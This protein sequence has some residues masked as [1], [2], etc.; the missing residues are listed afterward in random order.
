MGILKIIFSII[1]VRGMAHE[2][3]LFAQTTAELLDR[4]K[5]LEMENRKLSR[6]KRVQEKLM[7]TLRLNMST[8]ENF[9]KMMQADKVRLDQ[10]ISLLLRH[11][12][13]AIFLLDANGR[14][15]VGTEALYTLWG[16]DSPG[17][18]TGREFSSITK[19]Y[20]P[21]GLGDALE[22]AVQDAQAAEDGRASRTAAAGGKTFEIN[23]LTYG[24]ANEAAGVLV[25]MHDASELYGAKE[26]AERASRAKSDFLANMSHEMRTPMNAIIGMTS[27]ARGAPDLEKKDYCLGKIADASTHLLGVI[28]DILDMSKI[29]ANKFEL[30]YSEFNFEKML[31]KVTNVVNFRVEEKKQVFN[32]KIDQAIPKTLISDE[33]RLSQVIANLLSNAVKFT[34]EL[35]AITLTSQLVSRQDDRLRLRVSVTDTGIGISEEQQQRL[36]TSFVQAD[37]GISRKFGGTGLGLA[38]SRNIVEMM[39]G[40]I[41]VESTPNNGSCFTFE[42][43]A[44]PGE[45]KEPKSLLGPGINWGNL[46]VLV[47]DDS[48]DV[49]EYF[50]DIAETLGIHCDVAA[51]GFEACARIE[52]EG[53]YDI[54]FVDWKM[55]VM[56]GIELSYKIHEYGE[57]RSVVIMISSTEWGVI[58]REA[59][60]AGVA[61]FLQKPLFPST[62]ADCINDCLGITPEAAAAPKDDNTNCFLGHRVLLAEDIDINREIVIALMEP[63]GLEIDCAEN[64][65][66][67]LAMVEKDPSRYDL[68]LMDV[69][70][71]EMDGYEATRRIRA[72]D[73]PQAKAIP[74][75]AMTANVFREDIERCMAAGMDDHIGK[76]LDI[77]QV[78]EKLT[79]RLLK[80]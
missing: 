17:V 76:P 43:D 46:R 8:Q 30:S 58:E 67:A 55:P 22:S 68:I 59:K 73:D 19:R 62:I 65:A 60:A 74:I 27:I 16:A 77:G 70:M 40:R 66:V 12:P 61:K 54:Y 9:S 41:F 63:T 52:C 75:I 32:V 51:D 21:D 18:L 1:E 42:V 4:I 29:E 71:P 7:E 5:A 10:Q 57:G 28:N 49:R 13:D 11:C 50:S 44:K 69:Q 78:M 15:Q 14:F 35:G 23:A 72:L 31:M 47:V 64:G 3:R 33:Q 34:P 26:V 24:G 80:K 37:A 36:F 38:I 25:L 39:N 20:L 48:W 6:E 2:E 53:P 56:N 45:G 79:E